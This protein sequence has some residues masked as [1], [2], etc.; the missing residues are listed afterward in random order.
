MIK[1][2][3]KVSIII[4]VF[5]A[6]STLPLCLSSLVSL[7]YANIEVIFVDDCS[8]DGSL[9]KLEEF[10][11]NNERANNISSKIVHHQFNK[12]VAAARNTGL[13]H[14]SGDYIYYI[15]AD[16][17][18][19]SVTISEVVEEAVKTDADIVGFNW[20]LTFNKNERKMNQPRFSSSW[21]AI[22]KMLSGTMRWNLWLFLVKRKLYEE[23]KIHF[24]E[25][26]DMGEDMMVMM[27]LFTVANKVS[28]LDRP[29]YHYRQS[30]T[31]SLT[32][33]YS[34][35]HINQVT[36]NVEEVAFFL[37]NSKF[38]SQLGDMLAYLKLNIKLPLL[39]SGQKKQYQQWLSWFPESNVFATFNKKLSWRIRLIQY[40]A[41]RRQF[42]ALT[43]Y[44]HVVIRFVYGVIFR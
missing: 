33:K 35:D 4:P 24:I 16:D 44:Y 43:L 6:E 40:L 29:Y 23:N 32:K 42:W 10:V 8:T 17:I 15:D 25:G 38:A 37:N 2:N 39:V 22:E 28:F 19:D 41:K 21:D 26:M 7:D 18:V 34:Q 36:Q 9:L 27:K 20:F 11:A 1:D 12:G 5:N 3:P 13:D 30:N 14:V 31:A